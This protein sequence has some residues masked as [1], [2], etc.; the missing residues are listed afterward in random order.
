MHSLFQGTNNPP[1][2]VPMQNT[3]HTLTL[4]SHNRHTYPLRVLR[5]FIFLKICSIMVYTVLNLIFIKII[6]VVCYDNRNVS[7][8]IIGKC[9]VD[10][11]TL[12]QLHYIIIIRF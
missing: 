5:H 11:V 6:I 3:Q 9:E 7:F 12:L 10:Q 1:T 2:P 8:S 4:Q